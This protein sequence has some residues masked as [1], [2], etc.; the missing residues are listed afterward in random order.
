MRCVL[1]ASVL[2]SMMFCVADPVQALRRTA[3]PFENRFAASFLLGG[4]IPLGEFS[5]AD[6]GN[7]Q[8]GVDVMLELEYYVTRAVSV[9]FLLGGSIY[10]DKTF[11]GSLQTEVT[12]F[13]GTLKY[14]FPVSGVVHPYLRAGLASVDIEFEDLDY[15][16]GVDASLG[17]LAA[18]GFMARLSRTVSFDAQ[19]TYLWGGTDGAR[20]P[21]LDAEV[22]FNTQYLSIAG[23]LSFFFP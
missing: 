7:H 1:I 8:G 14:V 19:V 2:M 17:F 3:D 6:R 12:V 9:G 21:A 10:D 5:D 11:G 15:S 18:G 16:Y 13:G 20:V 4:A 23:G 22:N